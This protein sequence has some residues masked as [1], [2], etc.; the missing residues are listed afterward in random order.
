ML[1]RGRIPIGN[2][3]IQY[4]FSRSL[5]VLLLDDADAVANASIALWFRT[6]SPPGASLVISDDHGLDAI[7]LQLD[8]TEEDLV[9]AMS[10][11]F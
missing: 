1:F 7:E 6:L 11:W 2:L 3:S 5:N 10:D 9:Q 4:G 8:M